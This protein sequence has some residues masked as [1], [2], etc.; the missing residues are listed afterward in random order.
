[1]SERYDKYERFA[2]KVAKFRGFLFRYRILLISAALVGTLSL[3]GYLGGQGTIIEDNPFSGKAEANFIYGDAIEPQAK[4]LFT[5]ASY[6]Y[7]PEGLD[8]WTMAVPTTVGSYKLRA[9]SDTMFG[10]RYGAT[11]HFEIKPKAASL[12]IVQHTLPYGTEPT[13]LIDGL[14][15]G[16]RLSATQWNYDDAYTLTPNLDVTGVTIVNASGADVSANYDVSFPEGEDKKMTITPRSINVSLTEE[17]LVYNGG[18]QTF[19]GDYTITGGELLEGD[20]LHQED[21]VGTT[22]RLYQHSGFTVR[23][24]DGNDKTV[25]YDIETLNPQAY[26]IMHLDVTIASA[27][28]SKT[29]D[30]KG[31]SLSDRGEVTCLDSRGRP[32]PDKFT[33]S[34]YEDLS[35][36]YAPGT[37]Q[38]AYSY[39]LE[40]ASNYSITSVAGSL[41]IEK[42]PLH[43]QVSGNW[44]YHGNTFSQDVTDSSGAL[45]S[46]YYSLVDGTSLANGDTLKV[47]YSGAD[48]GTKTF[49]Y[50]ILRG[51]TIVS[52]C[53]DVTVNGSI[54]TSKAEL[55][56]NGKSETYTYDGKPHGLTVEVT[57]AQ[58]NDKVTL[59]STV[60]GQSITNVGQISATPAVASIRNSANEDRSANYTITATATASTT[61]TKRPLKVRLSPHFEYTG[62]TIDYTL[63]PTD[64][65]FQ[66]G[67]SLANGDELTITGSKNAIFGEGGNPFSATIVHVE[68]G[69]GASN[70]TGNYDITLTDNSTVTYHDLYI[71]GHE[72]TYVYDGST[73]T[74]DFS[75]SGT[76]STDYYEYSW[77]GSGQS[78]TSRMV[79]GTITATPVLT[80]ATKISTTEDTTSYYNVI[81]T[82]ATLTITKRPL[83]ITCNPSRTYA[84][85]VSDMVNASGTNTLLP[86]D[87]VIQTGANAGLVNGDYVSIRT[88]K[89]IF[90]L[91][92][93]EEPTYACSVF[94]ANGAPADDCYAVSIISDGYTANKAT[95]GIEFQFDETGTNEFE[96]VYDGTYSTPNTVVTGD[97]Y[98]VSASVPASTFSHFKS[99]V[100]V[101]EASVPMTGFTLYDLNGAKA[102]DYY[103]LPDAA[104]T[105]TMTITKR[106]VTFH[107]YGLAYDPEVDIVDGSLAPGQYF[108][109]KYIEPTSGSGYDYQITIKDGNTD[110]T[111]NYEVTI[112]RDSLGDTPLTLTANPFSSRYTGYMQYGS[113]D[114]VGLRPGDVITYKSGHGPDDFMWQ[115]AGSGTY[116]P[117]VSKITDIDGKDVTSTYEIETFE[118]TYEI[119]PAPLTITLSG[120]RWYNGTLFSE[121]PLYNGTECS[122]TVFTDDGLGGLTPISTDSLLGSDFLTV[123]PKDETI[124]VD[125]VDPEYT[126]SIQNYQGAS[127]VDSSGSYDITSFD[128]TGFTFHKASVTVSGNNDVFQYDGMAH[129]PSTP[130]VDGL[131]GNDALGTVTYDPTNPSITDPDEGNDGH[132]DYEITGATIVNGNSDR[133][134]YYDISYNGGSIEVDGKVTLDLGTY[135][136]VYTGLVQNVDD[137]LSGTQ[138]GNLDPAL[139][140]GYVFVK[141]ELRFLGGVSNRGYNAFTVDNIDLSSVRILDKN[142]DDVSANFKITEVTGGVYLESAVVTITPYAQG[143][144]YDGNKVNILLTWDFRLQSGYDITWGE[145]CFTV[146]AVCTVEAYLAGTYSIAVNS[147]NYE[148]HLYTDPDGDPVT[149]KTPLS[150]LTEIDGGLYEITGKT[151]A[152]SISKRSVTIETG[153]RREY[154]GFEVSFGECKLIGTLAD[155]DTFHVNAPLDRAFD[156]PMTCNNGPDVGWS[157]YITNAKN[158]DVTFCYRVNENWGTIVIDEW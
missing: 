92:P 113:I 93:A 120:E 60:T 10:K 94:H 40:G 89:N 74:L 117:Q 44:Q 81:S 15:S 41:T 42:R 131:Y 26:A 122:F 13:F 30:G 86:E 25:F 83:N 46:N 6:E 134:K 157:Y 35:D 23:D 119:L 77:Q 4:A 79:P 106:P 146:V 76:L 47:F 9:F 37:Y 150:E 116:E 73:R 48:Y 75:T 70:V 139:P 85:V 7:S 155:G 133:T 21:V 12:S 45:K 63:K 147:G 141:S 20:E 84:G 124:F 16:H 24:Q 126:I 91:G 72:D 108:E 100:G 103:D 98:S 69:K 57:G 123:T 59:S 99:G 67:T 64:Y 109:Y 66:D 14:L 156:K 31:F 27:G 18:P 102:N 52:N 54:T 115:F 128:A 153:D 154:T 151:I 2:R 22:V 80:K 71:T 140:G 38:N 137:Y 82:P 127:P 53:Y 97:L 104:V 118:A 88:T 149:D 95:C 136:G 5:G 68:S 61:I 28:R 29:Y 39:E 135:H 78:S 129:T 105:A 96:K 51:S 121:T 87:Y 112:E 58:G 90:S 152:F 19:S 125:A 130:T 1:M 138:V 56:L 65:V 3:S 62:T 11:H 111:A 49:S 145:S 110:V 36:Q 148:V 132:I 55:T 158:E 34:F 32:A 114:I 43:I 33:Y 17:T 50:Q 142:G 144:I 107:F 8:E 101:Y 143:K